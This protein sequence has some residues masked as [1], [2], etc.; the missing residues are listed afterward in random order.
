MERET[1]CGSNLKRSKRTAVNT[2]NETH[3]IRTACGDRRK[4]KPRREKIKGKKNC[5]RK[6]RPLGHKNNYGLT[7]FFLSRHPRAQR[8]EN[9]EA[10]SYTLNNTYSL[11]EIEIRA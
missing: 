1:L 9:F 3:F 10:I 6:I 11:I 2:G 7:M 8:A 4:R 5:V